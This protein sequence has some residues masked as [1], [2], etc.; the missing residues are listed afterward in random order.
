MRIS[1]RYRIS[2][3][4]GVVSR[5]GSL[6]RILEHF[7]ES[8]RRAEVRSLSSN[9]SLSPHQLFVDREDR[10]GDVKQCKVHGAEGEKE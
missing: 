9:E 7:R 3:T 2:I 10:I 1:S 4:R 5:G 6:S 8:E